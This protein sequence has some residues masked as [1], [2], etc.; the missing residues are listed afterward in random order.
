MH[1]P[2]H[3]YWF[4]LPCSYQSRLLVVWRFGSRPNVF[5]AVTTA[6]S[7]RWKEPFCSLQGMRNRRADVRGK[8]RAITVVG[9]FSRTRAFVMRHVRT[10]LRGRLSSCP[11]LF[12]LSSLTAFV[13]GLFRKTSTIPNGTV[14]PPLD[15]T[16]LVWVMRMSSVLWFAVCDINQ[17]LAELF[18]IH[19]GKA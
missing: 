19:A 5:S 11:S 3:R 8:N 9:T 6:L 12:Q 13:L 7:V 4:R 14:R 17:A 10:Q 16:S 18:P 15:R 2:T 1:N